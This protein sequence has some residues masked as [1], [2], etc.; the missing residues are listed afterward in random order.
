MTA[1]RDKNAEDIASL[2]SLS[3]SELHRPLN[4]RHTRLLHRPTQLIIQ[5][6]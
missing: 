3:V 1:A 5:R 2:L 6:G 4:Q